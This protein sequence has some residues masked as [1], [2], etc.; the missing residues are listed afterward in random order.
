MLQSGLLNTIRRGYL[1]RS[2]SASGQIQFKPRVN[3][4]DVVA[5]TE[6]FIENS[7][8][9][10]VTRAKPAVVSELYKKYTS[11]IQELDFLR[12]ERNRI[13][14]IKPPTEESIQLGKGIKQKINAA[15]ITVRSL[16]QEL[17]IEAA[18][19]PND[20]HPDVPDGISNLKVIE[21]KKNPKPDYS[22]Q[23]K[24]HLEL[25]TSLGILNFEAASKIAGPKFSILQGD[26]AILEIAI[27]Q[28]ILHK[29][30][31]KGFFPMITPDLAHSTVVEGCGFQPRGDATQIYKIHTDAADVESTDLCLVGTSEI[32]LAGYHA[33]E[34]LQGSDL[35]IRY[36]GFS[37]C[38]RAEAGGAGAAS[39]GLYR[40][41]QFSK[42]EMFIFC[43]EDQSEEELEYM[44][45]IQEE[46]CDDLG[47]HW[48]TLNMAAEELGSSAFK[49]YDVE[50]WMP[51]R[52]EFGEVASISNCTDY[53][54]RRLNIR[55][56]GSDSQRGTTFAYTLNGTGGA[57]PRLILALLETHQNPDGSVSIPKVLHDYM[58]GCSSH[59]IS[60]VEK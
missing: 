42:V 41:H 54:S 4:K 47:L 60:K 10:N 59:V 40:L 13:S 35:P 28:W 49:K 52:E 23:P 25:G 3:Y 27:V 37:H 12:Q 19:L 39:K 32:A 56:K 5:R 38:F 53:Q 36:A 18:F 30:R 51:G 8:R 48:R 26:G 57:V 31:T 43:T 6:Y 16:L 17:E 46:I 21:S 1:V 7:R 15:E 34:I 33:G 11:E 50:V 44:R 58:P 2:F 55:Y 45:S 9:R 22:F 24:D 14:K 20:T 29:L